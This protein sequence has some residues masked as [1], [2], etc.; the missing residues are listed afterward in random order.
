[1][2][3]LESRLRQ[4]LAENGNV[5]PRSMPGGTQVR[6][7]ARRV[8][9]AIAGIATLAAFVATFWGDRLGRRAVLLELALLMAAGG[10]VIAI[11]SSPLVIGLAAFVGLVNGMGRD[12]GASLILEQAIL[13]STTTDQD[14]TRAFAWYNVMQDSGGALGSLAAA[15]PLMVAHGRVD[16]HQE[17][18]NSRRG[19]R[20][21]VAARCEPR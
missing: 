5:G 18:R 13:P 2:N 16:D 8:S 10:A 21:P 6:I 4:S 20:R 1:M 11:G 12:R 14:R 3:D 17:A 15:L 7:R 19:T 9:K